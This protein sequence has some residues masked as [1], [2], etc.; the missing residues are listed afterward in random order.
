MC[1]LTRV[2][3]VAD[4]GVAA[5]VLVQGLDPDDLGACRG[6]AGEAGLVAGAEEGRRVVVAVLNVN[7]H[8]HK[9]PLHRDLL[10]THLKW[11]KEMLR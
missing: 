10:V 4:V 9:V 6:R 5:H 2:E 8:L 7:H 1:K 11:S 3:G